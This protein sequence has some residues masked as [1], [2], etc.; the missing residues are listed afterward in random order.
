MTQPRTSPP[1]EGRVRSGVIRPRPPS[2]CSERTGI[3]KRTPT[4]EFIHSI[5]IPVSVQRSIWTRDRG[6]TVTAPLL[7][8]GFS[9]SPGPVLEMLPTNRQFDAG[10]AAPEQVQ[11]GPV[12]SGPDCRAK[13]AVLDQ[14]RPIGRPSCW[15]ETPPAHGLQ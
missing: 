14:D 15:M 5:P 9:P 8:N 1:S 4:S 11:R 13:H 2:L 10:L 7:L 12:T 3:H 6:N